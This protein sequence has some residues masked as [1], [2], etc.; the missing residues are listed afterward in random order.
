MAPAQVYDA[1]GCHG[2][3]TS[4]ALSWEHPPSG[5]RSFAVLMFDQDAPGGGFW[6]WAVF[7]IPAGVTSFRSGAGTPASHLLP[8]GAIQVNNDW[9]SQGYG[10]PCPP[11]GP[12]HHYRL[13]LYALRVAKLGLDANASAA[14]VAAKVRADALAAAEIVGLYGR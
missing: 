11:A 14:Q 9:G 13:I 12:P 4:P 3:N 7:D 8:Q 6:H 10:G 1:S 5:T 2:G